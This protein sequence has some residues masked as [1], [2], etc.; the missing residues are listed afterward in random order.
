MDKIERVLKMD[1]SVFLNYGIAGLIL[2]VFYKLITN[3][4]RELRKAIEKLRETIDK[5]NILMEILKTEL[6]NS[7]KKRENTK[8]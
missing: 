7:R 8:T 2:Y 6:L 3:E 1:I 5:Q 4:L